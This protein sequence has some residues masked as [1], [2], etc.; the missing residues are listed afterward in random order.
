MKHLKFLLLAVA[1]C[2]SLMLALSACG[3]SDSGSSSSSEKESESESESKQSV[4]YKVTFYYADMTNVTTEELAEMI[5]EDG[6]L[7][8]KSLYTKTVVKISENG[9][10]VSGP[11][12]NQLKQADVRGY[13]RKWSTNDWSND[14]DITGD[15]DVYASYKPL[16]PIVIT[17][18]NAN[19]SKICDL[20]TYAT[21]SIEKN[22]YPQETVYYYSA[23]RLEIENGADAPEGY[24]VYAPVDLNGNE[25]LMDEYGVVTTDAAKAETQYVKA[26]E[27]EKLS[28]AQAIPFGAY[29]EAWDG[30]LSS[31]KISGKV[32]AMIGL[33]DDVIEKATVTVDGLMD[34]GYE[35]I[36]RLYPAVISNKR[37]ESWPEAGKTYDLL[38]KYGYENSE[39]IDAAIRN[40][41]A[42][43]EDKNAWESQK[44]EYLRY[45]TPVCDCGVSHGP[46]TVD[47]YLAWDGDD[48]FVYA[49]VNDPHVVSHG[50]NYCE[51]IANPYENDG[52]EIWYGIGGDF[53][54]VCLDAFG[55]KLYGAGKGDKDTSAYIDYGKFASKLM[56]DDGPISASEISDGGIVDQATSME[57]GIIGY[58]VEF[59]F[60]AY[61]EPILSEGQE[62][63][64]EVSKENWGKKLPAGY[65]FSLSIQ[66]NDIS[67]AA[68]EEIVTN[69]VN[70]SK[71]ESNEEKVATID[72]YYAEKT[73]DENPNNRVNL[74][75][76]AKSE[77]Q[78]G[79]FTLVLG[80]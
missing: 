30:K 8:D 44:A 2:M 48:V 15:L 32:T 35:L 45:A 59:S 21:Y 18:V 20:N 17:F 63:G 29:F 68:P 38:A 75:I 77:E 31:L 39:E 26:D 24:V 52:V 78:D 67:E 13:S 37:E 33:A 46:I 51:S 79:V 55:Y 73:T 34:E 19:G 76:Q 72:E 54:K 41:L 74:G 12:I 58:A 50:R 14:G 64:D 53:N 60:P 6:V 11:A 57:A 23:S 65:I 9:E 16:T 66:V 28:V 62:L 3:P 7:K 4:E 40:G 43:A 25:I 71:D 36:G 10:H 5:D 42:T 56:T 47:L 70:Q 61:M 22:E 69:Y 80:E 1:L 49:V 27:E